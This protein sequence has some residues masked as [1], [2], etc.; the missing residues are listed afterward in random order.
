MRQL[1]Q[2]RG[3]RKPFVIHPREH[4]H[5][6]ACQVNINLEGEGHTQII[7]HSIP[8]GYDGEYPCVDD[9]FGPP[10]ACLISPVA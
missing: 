4:G 7:A 2:R 8:G 3:A 9:A 1:M 6:S 5:E 10:M